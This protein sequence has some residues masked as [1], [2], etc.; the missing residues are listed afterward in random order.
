MTSGNIIMMGVKGR[1][2]WD[3]GRGDGTVR[4]VKLKRWRRREGW[5]SSRVNISDSCWF[6]STW[7]PHYCIKT[8]ISRSNQ[9]KV[10]CTRVEIV[11]ETVHNLYH[12]DLSIHAQWWWWSAVVFTVHLNILLSYIYLSG[13]VMAY[14]WV[15]T[16]HTPGWKGLRR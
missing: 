16:N 1:K 10:T 9:I 11:R 4:E 6:C 2:R 15:V 5:W 3:D 12:H 14:F 7:Q 8:I 13:K